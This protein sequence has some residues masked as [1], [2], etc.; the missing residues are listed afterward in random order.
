MPSENRPSFQKMTKQLE[1][2]ILCGK[3]RVGDRLPPLRVLSREFGLTEYATHQGLKELQRLGLVAIRR[4]SGVYVA[5]RSGLKN[6]GWNV[7]VFVGTDQIGT[8]YL[9][10]ALE[11]VEDVAMK[12]DCSLT[13][14]KRD[15]YQFF[16]SQPPLEAVIGEADGVLLLGEYDYLPLT[17]PP[18]IPAVGIE[19]GSFCSGAVS[20]VTLDPLAAA[21]LAVD[22]FR[23]RRKEYVEVHYFKG[24]PV[25]QCRAECFCQK[26]QRY[27]R[28]SMRPYELEK[29]RPGL[30]VP[31]PATGMLFC[32]GTR[33][34]AYLRAY[35]QQY[36]VNLTQT[37]AV[38]SMDGK[39]TLM[40]NYLPVSNISID[41]RAA[42]QIAF[43]ELIRRLKTPNTEPQRIYLMPHLQE[44]KN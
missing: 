1:G 28:F 42:G 14:R 41:W 26:W 25:F 5:N 7:C 23:R 21:D 35:Y 13:L 24:G 10:C 16:G 27:G 6:D 30:P 34:E 43:A 3:Y 38:L 36:G 12:S 11:G 19:M 33:C 9:Y 39:S 18:G 37:N 32:S 17:L 31:D 2:Q 40:P 29:V 44:I 22:F 8:G 15:Y 20:P 4:G